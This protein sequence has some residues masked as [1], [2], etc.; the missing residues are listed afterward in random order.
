MLNLIK[1]FKEGLKVIF[2]IFEN[3]TIIL[4]ELTIR[5]DTQKRYLKLM[6]KAFV[7]LNLKEIDYR[8]IDF[9]SFSIQLIHFKL[10]NL[11]FR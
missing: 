4:R 2:V 1:Y 11:D 5:L 8:S 10:C 9:N 3:I 6:S 7:N